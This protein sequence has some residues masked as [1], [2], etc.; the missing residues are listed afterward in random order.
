MTDYRVRISDRFL[1]SAV[2]AAVEAY[3]FGARGDTPTETIGPIWG[4]RRAAGD[5]EI[6]YL[7]RLA[8]SIAAK[9]R[10]SSVEARAEATVLMANVMD[11]LAPEMT[12]LGDFHSHPC[13]DRAEVASTTGYEFSDQDFRCFLAD[14]LLWSRNPL[15]PVMVVVT[16]CR[17]ERVHTSDHREIRPNVSR[18]YIGEFRF[19]INVVAGYFDE[20]GERRHTGNKHSP[21]WV[22]LNSRFFND[23]GDRVRDVPLL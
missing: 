1:E 8:V 3:C 20:H 12:L 7:D 17:L 2:L 14:H 11:R 5:V 16:V 10:A 23:S 9:R 22:D 13:R 21:V 4:F 15:G 19:W 18:F 6:I